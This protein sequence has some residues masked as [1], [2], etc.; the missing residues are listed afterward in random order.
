MRFSSEFWL[1]ICSWLIIVHCFCSFHCSK[2]GG[3][4]LFR[5]SFFFFFLVL[6]S[7]KLCWAAWAS[8]F[9]SLFNDKKIWRGKAVEGKYGSTGGNFSRA[10]VVSP[11][12]WVTKKAL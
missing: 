8:H 10:T 7:M 9:G 4:V 2:L 12:E 3:L 11:Y 5:G 6:P 1:F